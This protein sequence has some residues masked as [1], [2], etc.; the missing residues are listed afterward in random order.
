MQ[1]IQE[2][3][4]KVITIEEDG[5]HILIDAHINGFSA[6]ILIDTGASKTVFD[7]NYFYENFPDFTPVKENRLSSGLG[8]NTI[9]SHAAIIEEFTMGE[10]KIADFTTSLIDL[11]MVN[12]TYQKLNLPKINGILGGDLLMQLNAII[13]YK[14]Q[15]ISFLT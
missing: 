4:F 2:L 12:D 13:D 3:N 15:K 8:N 14:N 6:L 11:S 10:I 9:Q 5:F 7:L 1:Q